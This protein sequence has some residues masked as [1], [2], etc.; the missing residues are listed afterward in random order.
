MVVLVIVYQLLQRDMCC[1][2]EAGGRSDEKEKN[3][4][5]EL[6][7]NFYD[8]D[9][10]ET[11]TTDEDPLSRKSSR[12]S[13]RRSSCDMAT[14]QSGCELRIG[15]DA[16]TYSDQIDSRASLGQDDAYRYGGKI[17]IDF[18]YS[19]STQQMIV[20][21]IKASD[22]PSRARGGSSAV[23]V[24]LVLLPAKNHRFKTKVR[25]ASNPIFNETFIF[26]RIDQL[27]ISQSSLRLRIYGQERYNQGRLIGELIQ[28]LKDLDLLVQK[29]EDERRVW[30]TLK[31]KTLTVKLSFG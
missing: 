27:S 9:E 20:I 8:L 13:S 4:Y 2:I 21:V 3:G 10:N 7:Q 17:F 30:K 28:P 24:R 15:E 23:Q 14:S 22:I 5:K 16:S 18:N 6:S 11:F 25:P 19:T 29:S 31:P 1:K 26:Q 12:R